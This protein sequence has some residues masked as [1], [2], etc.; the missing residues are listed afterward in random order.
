MTQLSIIFLGTGGSWPTIKRNVTSIAIKR[1]SEI[2]LFDLVIMIGYCV[3]VI[4]AGIILFAKFG[5][6]K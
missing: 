5:R 6:E 2:V 4:I 3:F 1:G